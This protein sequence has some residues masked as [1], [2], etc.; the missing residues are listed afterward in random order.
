[1]KSN[2]GKRCAA[3]VLRVIG[4]VLV[5]LVGGQTL[6]ASAGQQTLTVDLRSRVA[7][8]DAEGQFS[9][10]CEKQ[11]W[12][13]DETAIINCDMWNQHW[14]RAATNRVAELAPVMNDVVSTAMD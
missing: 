8:P 4:I 3:R 6:A 11:Q 5:I 14:C 7:I 1:M 9:V 13:P 2:N 10:A 12:D